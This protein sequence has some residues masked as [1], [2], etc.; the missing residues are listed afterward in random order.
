[1]KSIAIIAEDLS[2]PLD[3]GFKKASAAVATSIAGLGIETRVFARKSGGFPLG[4]A[5]LPANK[6]LVDSAFSRELRRIRPEA[7]LY[8]PEAAATAMS[9]LRARLIKRQAGGPP[10]VLL[11]LQSRTYPW[12]VAPLLRLMRPDLALVLSRGAA[13]QMERLGVPAAA[14]PLGVDTA[15]FK[16]CDAGRK[17]A[18][19]HKYGVTADKVI[20]HTGHVS[21]RRNL[22]VLLGALRPGRQLVMVS[23]TATRKDAD[24]ASALKASMVILVDRFVEDVSEVFHLADCYL[25][26]TESERGA[27]EMPLSVLEAMACNLPVVTTAFGGIPDFFSEG[28]GLFIASSKEEF[29]KK[30]ELAL[31][32][33]SAEVSTS[34]IVKNFTW[35]EVARRMAD[36]IA[37]VTGRDRV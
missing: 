34:D 22:E 16:P 15:V 33:G 11:S 36:A 35:T 14:V 31:A 25:F 10:I 4:A 19:R 12:P 37:R 17:H 6:L 3:E 29:A 5:R 21:R 20:L 28:R 32:L 1:M 9:F 26:P 13:G 27:I 7:I 18:L 24:V 23:S 30:T 8:I 2:A